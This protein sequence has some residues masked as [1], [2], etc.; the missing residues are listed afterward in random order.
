MEP[1]TGAL[2]VASAECVNAGEFRA[3]DA[4]SILLRPLV[5]RDF[6]IWP[7][8]ERKACDGKQCREWRL[9]VRL[10]PNASGELPQRIYDLA[11]TPPET[12]KAGFREIAEVH[13]CKGHVGYPPIVATDA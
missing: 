6:Q 7:L 2:T 3:L 8:P 11:A 10:G 5:G 12:R 4:T 9:G 1:H 13:R